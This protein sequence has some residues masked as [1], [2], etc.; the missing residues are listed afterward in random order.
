MDLSTA[1]S[2]GVFFGIVAAILLCVF[3]VPESKGQ[4]GSLTVDT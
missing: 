3:V 1:V 2:A 4:S